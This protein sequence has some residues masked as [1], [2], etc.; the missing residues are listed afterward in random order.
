M[1]GSARGGRRC[2][3]RSRSSRAS[4]G[5]RPTPTGRRLP[6]DDE[7]F[8]VVEGVLR[9]DASLDAERRVAQRRASMRSTGRR[10]RVGQDRQEAASGRSAA[11]QPTRAPAASSS[12]SSARWRAE[13]VDEW[14]AGRRV[15]LPVQLRRPSRYLDPGVPDHERALARRGTTLVGTVKSGA[16]VDVLARGRLA[17]R[18]DRRVR[19]VRAARDR[20][21]R[22][23]LEPAVRGDRRG[24]RDR[25]PRGARRRRAAAAAG[26]R[27]VSRH[28]DLGRQH[29]DSRRP[30]ARGVPAG[31]HGSGATAMLAAIAVLLA[32][33]R[34]VGGGASV[35]RATLM[36]VVYFGARAV[37]QRSP[38][39]NAL[40]RRRGAARRRRSAVG[41]RPGVRPD[42]RRDARD[43]V[44][45]AG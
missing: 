17:R 15:R 30:A 19:A 41:R 20:R 31:R 35:D 26:G 29:R 3:S 22:R 8:A 16:L 18:G 1:R 23:P 27:H 24:H 5:A 11:V 14:R 43:P 45:V 40:A 37:D 32:Y 7:A 2:G 4:S 10:W 28:R 42:V 33:A 36:A 38:P 21:R 6:E 44:V 25:R 13:R 34:L 9:A 39:L 12:P